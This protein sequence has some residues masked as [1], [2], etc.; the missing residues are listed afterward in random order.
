MLRTR[1]SRLLSRYPQERK[2]YAV[3]W[4]CYI[5]VQG[6]Y[7]RV[8]RTA[9]LVPDERPV[10]V[11]R[12]GRVYDGCREAFVTGL[13]LGAPARQALR[14]APRAVRVDLSELDPQHAARA[15]WDR[16][17]AHT[18]YIEPGA[19][20]Q[21]FLALPSPG[22]ALTPA[23]KAEAAKL[24]KMAA[25]FG[26]VAFAGVG[27]SKVVA[28]AAALACKEAW[29]LRRQGQAARTGIAG[30][31]RRGR[32]PETIAFVEPGAEARFL[33][34]LPVSCLPVPP[35]VQRRLVRLGIRTIG[36]AARI[37]EGE[38]LRQLGP[39]G[40]QVW[41]WSRGVDQEPV[42]PAYPPRTLQRRVE[43]APEVRN[44]DHLEQVAGRSV[45][46]LAHQLA[47]KGEG[48]QQVAL[49][50]EPVG[51]LPV[52]TARTLAKLQQEPYPLQQA[53]RTLLQQALEQIGGS[54]ESPDPAA[55]WDGGIPI[56]ALEVELGLIGPM[57][58]QQLS[59]W[60]DPGRSEREERLHRALM[61]LHER[62]P[63]R[64][65]GLGPRQDISWRERMLQFSD[66]YRWARQERPAPEGVR[67]A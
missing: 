13:T 32:Q 37:A 42:R 48:A 3:Q 2:G 38:W 17:L 43:F 10:V 12:E 15:W 35:E 63:V 41:L 24:A 16:C 7:A 20:H 51:G 18:P 8:A 23:V 19:P 47:Q 49:T 5:E 27:T 61:L 30:Q 52:R 59:L 11:L 9:G 6:L 60:D 58:W 40:R 62:F 46:L 53:V 55:G 33:A 67:P 28:R 14:D 26:F 56:A 50:L 57:P 29:L 4:V 36:E 45:A 65:V 21:V 54:R 25:A 22:D 31:P 44:R 66:P 64:I 34:P 1:S 39:V